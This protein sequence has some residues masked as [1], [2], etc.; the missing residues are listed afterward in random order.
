MPWTRGE[1]GEGLTAGP[2]E[3]Q[4]EGP[5]VEGVAPGGPLGDGSGDDGPPHC[6]LRPSYLIVSHRVV[7]RVS[8]RTS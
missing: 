3:L 1:E 4:R 2:A 6:T 8:H 5:A 7:Q